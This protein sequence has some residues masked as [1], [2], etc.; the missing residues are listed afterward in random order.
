MLLPDHLFCVFVYS[1]ITLSYSL[2]L[3]TNTRQLPWWGEADSHSHRS[4]P[5][6]EKLSVSLPEQGVAWDMLVLC[7]G[8]LKS[9]RFILQNSC[10]CGTCNEA[11]L[12][13]WKPK[14]INGQERL[15]GRLYPALLGHFCSQRCHYSCGCVPDGNHS[16][17]IH[18][19]DL[20]LMIAFLWPCL[21]KKDGGN[22]NLFHFKLVLGF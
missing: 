1:F 13:L 5:K 20:F 7:F 3:L 9:R 22:W 19:C 2:I 4:V 11:L 8:I 18:C 15:E 10:V 16:F 21:Y 12:K 17:W 14:D 6:G